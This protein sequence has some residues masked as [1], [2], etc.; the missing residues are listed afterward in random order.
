MSAERSRRNAPINLALGRRSRGSASASASASTS[1]SASAR[2]TQLK[3]Q[4]QSLS[5]FCWV[6]AVV[7]RVALDL[8]GQAL[9]G[10]LLLPDASNR[11]LPFLVQHSVLPSL[12]TAPELQPGKR[13]ALL[14]GHGDDRYRVTTRVKGQF[15]RDGVLLEMPRAPKASRNRYGSRRD[16]HGAEWRFKCRA[17]GRTYNVA[18]ISTGGVG[19][20]CDPV[21]SIPFP[22]TILAGELQAPG[23][24]PVLVRFEILRKP[25]PIPGSRRVKVAARFHGMG[26]KSF[27]GVA[28]MAFDAM[29]LVDELKSR[30]R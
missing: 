22:G 24:E 15:G 12:A 30:G 7:D 8:N 23:F 21:Q 5:H 9:L 4:E 11:T 18:D 14:Y 16:V 29:D 19:L 2:D 1:A 17:S 26:R 13:V 28:G 27:T 3:L 25:T 10:T 6:A 20:A